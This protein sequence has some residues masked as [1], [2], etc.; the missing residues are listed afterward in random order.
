MDSFS[1][2]MHRPSVICGKRLLNGDSESV[3]GGPV[4]LVLC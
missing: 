2:G 1:G 4:V 3:H